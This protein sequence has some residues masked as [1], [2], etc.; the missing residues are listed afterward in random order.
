MT[1][2]ERLDWLQR[3]RCSVDFAST[4]GDWV[5]Q[6]AGQVVGNIG[7]GCTAREA[8][9]NAMISTTPPAAPIIPPCTEPFSRCLDCDDRGGCERYREHRANTG[10]EFPERSGGKLE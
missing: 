4:I 5:V 8:I 9:D 6:S 7:R 2:T 3:N 1:D 10:I